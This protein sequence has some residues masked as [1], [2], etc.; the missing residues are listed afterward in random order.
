MCS[1][2]T[3][4]SVQL[5][6]LSGII[7]RTQLCSNKQVL[8]SERPLCSQILRETNKLLGTWK[9]WMYSFP[10]Y[11]ISLLSLTSMLQLA[12]EIVVLI[13]PV[14]THLKCETESTW[15]GKCTVYVQITYPHLPL[16]A[17]HCR[18]VWDQNFHRWKT[19]H[20]YSYTQ[21]RLNV[22]RRHLAGK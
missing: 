17:S 5:S 15:F 11:H 16:P 2:R 19:R 14:V 7:L 12:N 3:R 21:Y 6:L 4:I 20:K 10:N 22:K 8:Q 13:Y 18:N 1:T 9:P